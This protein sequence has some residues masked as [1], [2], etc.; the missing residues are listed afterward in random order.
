MVLMKNPP[1]KIADGLWMLGVDR[2]PLYLFQGQGEAV[3]FEGGVGPEGPLVLRQLESLG[4]PREQI[5][6]IVIPHAHPDH[7]MAVPLLRASLPGA[8]VLAS[9]AAAKTLSIEKVV[10]LFCQL[11]DAVTDALIREGRITDADRR[12]PFAEKQIAV[13]RTLREGD[14]LVVGGV[15]FTTLETPGHSDCSLSFHQPERHLLL[16]SDAAEYYLDDQ[17]YW[18]P[19]YFAGYGAYLASLE[20]LAGLDAEILCRGHHGVIRGRDEVRSH[21]AAARAAA[22]QYHERIVAAVRAGKPVRQLAEELGAEV[23][24]KTQMLPLDFF[25]KNCGLLVKQS[26]AHEGIRVEK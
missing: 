16:I 2:Y 6:H 21:L 24:Q 17:D 4:V 14:T 26:L 11:D 13:D 23:Y 10:A 18:W 1:V 3:L 22:R 15:A 8:A 25:Q 5:K 20:R 9:A 19:N 12:P 7:V